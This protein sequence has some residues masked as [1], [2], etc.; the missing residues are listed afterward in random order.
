MK[1]MEEYVLLRKERIVNAGRLREEEV[2]REHRVKWRRFYI[3][4]LQKSSPGQE[5]PARAI[6]SLPI[7]AR[8]RLLATHPAAAKNW[9]ESFKCTDECTDKRNKEI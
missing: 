2:T 5:I 9:T 7:K 6:A 3:Q 8:L 1:T 4:T